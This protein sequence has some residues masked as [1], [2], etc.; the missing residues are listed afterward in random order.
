MDEAGWNASFLRHT[1]RIAEIDGEIVGFADM[2]ESGYLDRLYVHRD[3][4]RKGVARALV[5]ALERTVKAEKYTTHA[6][7]TARGFFEKR[8][9]RVVRTQQVIRYGVALTNFVMEW[10]NQK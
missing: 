6:S 9:W 10:E 2:N 5:D 4:Q 7:I 3:H 1:T 8:G